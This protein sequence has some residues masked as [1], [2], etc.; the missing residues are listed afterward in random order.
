MPHIEISVVL[1]R[2]D[3]QSTQPVTLNL[4]V[5]VSTNRAST[6]AHPDIATEGDDNPT[7]AVPTLTVVPDSRAPDQSTESNHPLP[8]PD[9]VPI[10]ST[11]A[12]PQDQGE[13]SL[14]EKAQI[15]LD[16]ADE[17]EKSIDRSDTWEG[18]VGRI[19]WLMDTLG[20]VAGVR[21]I[22]VSPFIN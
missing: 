12:M 2:H 19:K 4:R 13:T 22:F 20:P 7:E 18:V 21:V 15:G 8:P 10:Q 6:G 17:L 16:R 1:D 3:G 11:T 5:S 14:T 9:H